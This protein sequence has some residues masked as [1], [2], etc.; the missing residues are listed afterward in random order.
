VQKKN[1]SLDYGVA[2]IPAW[3]AGQ[4]KKTLLQHNGLYVSGKSKN[5]AAAYAFMLFLTNPANSVMLTQSSGWVAARS[6]VDWSPLVQKIPQYAGFV[7]PPADMQYYLEPVL[8]PWNEIQTRLADQLPAAFVDASLK[9]NPQKVADTVKK[10]AAQTDAI[11]K[12]AG[13][14]GT[15]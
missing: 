15:T 11:L 13:L 14:Y 5:A 3:A 4:P 2:Q 1:P 8:G 10:W 12:E 6:D 7:S 9:D